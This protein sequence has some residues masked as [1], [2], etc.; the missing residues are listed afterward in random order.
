M[1]TKQMSASAGSD[2]LHSEHHSALSAEEI[3]KAVQRHNREHK[4]DAQKAVQQA[5]TRGKKH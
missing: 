3:A 4:G 5:A 1:D 2:V